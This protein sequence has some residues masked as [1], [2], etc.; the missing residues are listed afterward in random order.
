MMVRASKS[1]A[2]ARFFLPRVEFVP[3]EV[4]PP[5]VLG[6]ESSLRGFLV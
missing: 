6:S 1:M 2:V 3:R 5:P 4:P